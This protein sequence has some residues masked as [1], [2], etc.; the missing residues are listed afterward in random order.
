MVSPLSSSMQDL[1]AEDDSRGAW[2]PS[3][4]VKGEAH[5]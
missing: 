3:G 1:F 4:S 5:D 2:C